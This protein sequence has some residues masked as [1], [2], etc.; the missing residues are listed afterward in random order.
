MLPLQIVALGIILVG[1]VLLGVD[2]KQRRD[3]DKKH[4]N[5][6]RAG[7]SPGKPVA[8]GN[9]VHGARSVGPPLGEK[10]SVRLVDTKVDVDGG[11]GAG[12]NRSRKPDA[13][14][15]PDP[16]PSLNGDQEA[17]GGKPPK[18][19]ESPGGEPPQGTDKPKKKAKKAVDD[20]QS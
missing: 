17:T 15:R 19:Q 2:R 9:G 18:H 10:K 8:D 5:R 12:D 11:N 6:R 16:E 3:K 13:P 1:T 7:D 14:A 20:A 4:D